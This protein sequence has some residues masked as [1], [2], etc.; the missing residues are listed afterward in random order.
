MYPHATCLL[1]PTTS[2]GNPGNVTPI[3]SRASA[4]LRFNDEA[5]AIPRVRQ[6]QAEVHV[7]GEQRACQLPNAYAAT[8]QL[9][10][11][12]ISSALDQQAVDG[13]GVR[14]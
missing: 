3:R 6:P 9:L 7:V 11:P 14:L 4:P 5:R 2:I 13:D 10:L 8:A 1:L 12:T